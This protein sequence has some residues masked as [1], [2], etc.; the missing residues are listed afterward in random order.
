MDFVN[1]GELF[2]YLNQEKKFK[3]DRVRQYAAELVDAISYLHN[4]G[5][6]YRDIKP[7][8][9]LLDSDGHI[10]IIDFGLAKIGVKQNER[11]YSFCGTPEYMAPEIAG[12]QGHSFSSD[13]YS[14]GTL[15]YEMLAGQPPHYDKDKFIMLQMRINDPVIMK[16][17]FSPEAKSLLKGMLESDPKQR[18]GEKEIRNHEFFYGVDWEAV[19]TRTNKVVFVP[20]VAGP[21]DVRHIDSQFTRESLKETHIDRD[22]VIHCLPK[23]D[24]KKLNFS[25]F[26]YEGEQPMQVLIGPDEE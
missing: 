20:E 16:K 3:Q 1:G 15:I 22:S 6:I 21:A 25:H 8:N 11:T 5:V 9:V 4:N 17:F 13:W 14:L 18:F 26:S 19:S 7:E 24:L 23:A 2:T 10:R 12:S